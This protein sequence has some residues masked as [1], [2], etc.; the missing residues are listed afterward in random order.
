MLMTFSK[1]D[2]RKQCDFLLVLLQCSLLEFCEE[3]LVVN[4]EAPRE[5]RWGTPPPSTT[6]VELPYDSSHQFASYGIKPFESAKPMNQGCQQ[7]V[8][9]SKEF[10]ASDTQWYRQGE[11]CLCVTNESEL[12]AKCRFLGRHSGVPGELLEWK[13]SNASNAIFLPF[14]ECQVHLNL[15]DFLFVFLIFGHTVWHLGP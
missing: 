13:N 3:V 15:M 9:C 11:N 1:L 6:T 8:E 2:N 7:E 14:F 5:R 10:V 12:R 4:G